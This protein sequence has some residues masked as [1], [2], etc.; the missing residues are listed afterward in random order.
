MI[1]FE[2]KKF[3]VYQGPNYYLD[4]QAVVFNLVLDPDGPS[5]DF[6]RNQIVARLPGLESDYPDRLVSLF[7]RVLIEVLRMEIDLCLER[8]ALSRDGDEHV[9]AVE[10]L[11]DFVA[12]ESARFVADW[13]KAMTCE[14]GFDFD[15]GFSKLQVDFDRSLFG[16]PTFYSLVE[17]GLTRGIPVTYCREE[18]QYMWGYGKKQI[19][20]RSTTFH[21]DSIKDTEF[22]TYKDMVKDFLLMCGFPTPNGKNCFSEEEAVAEAC[23]QGFPVVVKPLAGHKGQGVTTSITTDDAVRSAF[24]KVLEGAKEHNIPFDGA[25]VEKQIFGTD[26]RLLSVNGRFAAALQ[27]V[28]AYVDGD[29]SSTIEE[30]IHVENRR[31]ERLDNARSPLCKIQIDE[32]LQ[33][34][35]ELQDLNLRSIPDAQQRI[36][37]RR[38]ANISAGGVSINVTETIHP[39]NIKLVEDIAKFFNVTCLGIDV[40]CS[41]ISQS[42]SEGDFGII[43]I[44]AGPG[45]FMH[46]APAVGGSIDVPGQIM[47]AYFPHEGSERIPIIAGNK[48]T[49]DLANGLYYRLE[50]IRQSIEFGSLTSE[51]VSFN[52]ESF[53]KNKHHDKNV[54]IVLR[55]PK[56]EFA[57]FNHTGHDI[58]DYGLIHQGADVVILDDPSP[59]EQI[60]ERDLRPDG[61]LIRI[62]PDEITITEQDGI[63]RSFPIEN[64]TSKEEVILTALEGM[65]PH[66]LEKYE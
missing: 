20:G 65:L 36:E 9:I 25:I 13:F 64:G 8:Y 31:V 14:E 30:L 48:I 34:Y 54:K 1:D 43:E 23:R 51:G 59:A 28:P 29:G 56:L 5:A 6:Y 40:L 52:G 49:L 41:D 2:V 42:W 16:G 50:A 35:L 60:L 44:N 24:S 39:K 33:E 61:A 53:H 21:T 4:R 17:A 12:E 10:Y 19:R 37:L 45:V 57:L 47:A 18:N 26:H 22:T 55:N 46:L 63:G 62:E 7:A 3:Y 11:D 38:V 15:K 27:R 66:L 58:D 32:D